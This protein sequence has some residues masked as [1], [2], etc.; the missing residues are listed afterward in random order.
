MIGFS[1]GEIVS[2]ASNTTSKEVSAFL[3]SFVVIFSFFQPHQ[4]EL[5]VTFG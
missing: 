4:R 1:P 2:G 3:H 5:R